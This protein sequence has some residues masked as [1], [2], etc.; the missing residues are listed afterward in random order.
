[1][2]GESGAKGR[3]LQPRVQLQK[4][5]RGRWEG[6]GRKGEP[7]ASSGETHRQI[8]SI[9]ERTHGEDKEGANRKEEEKEE[10]H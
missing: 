9:R 4:G 8:H 1:M 2:L 6:G 3:I 7:R 5:E 10:R